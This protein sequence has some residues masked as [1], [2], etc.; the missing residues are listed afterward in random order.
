MTRVTS[1]G[2]KRKY[3]EAG[4]AT[5]PTTSNEHDA[6]EGNAA[7]DDQGDSV[8]PGKKRKRTKKPKVGGGDEQMPGGIE[9][10]GEAL[11]VQGIGEGS[12]AQA[13]QNRATIMKKRGG[14]KSGYYIWSFKFPVWG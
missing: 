2:R 3:L 14:A 7:D 13:G 5:E 1:F 12:P 4:F 8:H 10:G 11:G 6:F 9:A